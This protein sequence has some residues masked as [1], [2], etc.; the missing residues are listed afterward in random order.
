MPQYTRSVRN[1]LPIP[2]FLATCVAL[3]GCGGGDTGDGADWSASHAKAREC[4]TADGFRVLGGP[5]PADDSD[6]PDFE[7][8]ASMRG[9]MAFIAFYNELSRAERYEP[10]IRKNVEKTGGVVERRGRVAVLW[11][12]PP[13]DDVERR[14]EDCL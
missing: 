11:T 4:L 5:R 8:I 1:L 13:P 6:A 12:K 3:A 9:Q 7:L 10:G 2:A 14:L